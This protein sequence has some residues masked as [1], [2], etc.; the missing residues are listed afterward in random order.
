LGAPGEEAFSLGYLYLGKQR[1]VTR[2]QAKPE[3][4]NLMKNFYQ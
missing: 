4:F 3:K 1:K 2:L